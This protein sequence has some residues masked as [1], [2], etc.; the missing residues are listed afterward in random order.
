MAY[1]T[2]K[3]RNNLRVSRNFVEACATYIQKR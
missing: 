2:Q 1:E 3:L